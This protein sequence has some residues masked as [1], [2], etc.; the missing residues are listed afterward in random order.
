[1]PCEGN[2]PVRSEGVGVMAVTACGSQQ[3][4]AY[5]AQAAVKLAAVP[6]GICAHGSG[7]EDKF[8]PK[9]GR[10]RAARFQQRLQMRL[11]GLLKTQCCL[12][13]I[14]SVRMASRQQRGLGDPN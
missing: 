14:A 1:M 8:V 3:L 2:Q 7:S 4:T 13:P 6:R 5:L 12:S 9:G 10:N 11:R